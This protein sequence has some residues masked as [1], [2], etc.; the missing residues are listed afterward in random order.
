MQNTLAHNGHSSV[1]WELQTW[2][3]HPCLA[4]LSATLPNLVRIRRVASSSAH[5][6]SFLSFFQN[7][8]KYSL[9]LQI[10]PEAIANSTTRRSTNKNTSMQSVTTEKKTGVGTP[11]RIVGCTNCHEQD[12]RTARPRDK[13]L[14][15]PPNF[16]RN[17]EHGKRLLC[18]TRPL[19]KR[20]RL[21]THHFSKPP[22]RTRRII[23]CDVATVQ[24]R[25]QTSCAPAR[26]HID[27]TR[28]AFRT[29]CC[30]TCERAAANFS[31]EV[32]PPD[33]IGEHPGQTQIL[34]KKH[35]GT[36]CL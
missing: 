33:E 4:Q 11:R 28:H 26:P 35:A 8:T 19:I 3:V 32:K 1:H 17:C 31:A 27:T 21:A 34:L 7:A 12:S 6:Q 9:V 13:T 24:T 14:L 2:R 10:M 22:C 23:I 25:I 16:L 15:G 5:V 18:H 30:H 36:Q 20:R 29:P